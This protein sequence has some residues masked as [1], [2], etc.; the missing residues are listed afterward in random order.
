MLS[1]G[2][3]PGVKC[4]VT[5]TASADGPEL[6]APCPREQTEPLT[7]PSSDRPE[8]RP[9]SDLMQC[10]ARLSRH[11]DHAVI[12]MFRPLI[13]LFSLAKLGK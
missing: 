1:A 12:K 3:G 6:L 7:A 13:H 11:S 2:V 9:S 10:N 5:L 4:R 8:P